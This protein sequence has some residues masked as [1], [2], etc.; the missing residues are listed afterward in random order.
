MNLGTS[1]LDT[2]MDHDVALAILMMSR[3]P[4]ASPGDNR[5]LREW[6]PGYVSREVE[7]VGTNIDSNVMVQPRLET[8]PRS[9]RIEAT[10][11]REHVRAT[12]RTR[13]DQSRWLLASAT[14]NSSY[15][16]Y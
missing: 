15:N 6:Q 10:K 9:S 1:V 14:A 8:R 5:A 12:S 3:Q 16:D 2:F 4:M 13:W 11:T 7:E